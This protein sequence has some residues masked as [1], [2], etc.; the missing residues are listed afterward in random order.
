MANDISVEH[1]VTADPAQIPLVTAD[2]LQI[3]SQPM[4]YTQENDARFFAGF[5]KVVDSVTKCAEVHSDA[6]NETT[7][8]LS[9]DM[10]LI[11]N[12]ASED[13]TARLKTVLEAQERLVRMLQVAE[14]DSELRQRHLRVNSPIQTSR[15]TVH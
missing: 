1:I 12:K 7:K 2:P 8:K 14:R 13:A 3:P 10:V 15:A 4:V 11:A 9:G 6:A 5:E